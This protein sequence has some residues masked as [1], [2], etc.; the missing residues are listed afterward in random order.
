MPVVRVHLRAG[1]EKIYA[2]GGVNGEW[3][4]SVVRVKLC[5]VCTALKGRDNL[6]Q[7]EER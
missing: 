4:M 6:A 2:G 1:F 3:C 5:N 7:G